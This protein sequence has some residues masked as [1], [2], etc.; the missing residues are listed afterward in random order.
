MEEEEEQ[1]ARNTKE[2]SALK[3][4]AQFNLHSRS[5]APPITRVQFQREAKKKGAQQPSD[6]TPPNEVIVSKKHHV[7]EDSDD[8]S[9]ESSAESDLGPSSSMIV[10]AQQRRKDRLEGSLKSTFFRSAVEKE[11]E[12]KNSQTES[13]RRSR[14]KLEEM[15]Q[16]AEMHQAAKKRRVHS[17]REMEAKLEKREEKQRE[18]SAALKVPAFIATSRREY[19]DKIARR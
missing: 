6:P 9:S 3:L 19:F 10:A 2:V 18:K 11:V 13:D 5:K 1:A 14:A 16:Q 15:R 8:S 4:A 7:E 12:V 17:V